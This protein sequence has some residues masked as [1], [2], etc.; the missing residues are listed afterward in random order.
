[1]KDGCTQ[2]WVWLRAKRRILKHAAECEHFP[3]ELREKIK[4]DM[5]YESPSAKVIQ[6]KTRRLLFSKASASSSGGGSFTASTR[7]TPE[8]STITEDLDEPVRKKIKPSLQPSVANIA[9]KAKIN[10]LTAQISPS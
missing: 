2:T 7:T 3:P 8:P 9:Q 1:M 5:G 6:M 4:A 10:E